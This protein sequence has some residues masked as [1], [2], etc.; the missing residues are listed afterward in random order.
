M[1]T[2]KTKQEISK[3]REGGKILAFVL[4]EL[5]KM[6]KPGTNLQDLENKAREL[7]SKKGAEPSFLGHKNYPAIICAS[8]NEEVVH[9]PPEKRAL[10]QGDVLSLDCGVKYKGLYT[11]SAITFPIGKVSPQAKKLIKVTKEALDKA[12]SVA[13]PK[14]TIGDISAAIQN[15][16]E[17]KGFSVVKSLVG[18]GVGHAIHE[19]PRIPNF[20]E[21]GT[22]E[23]IKPG[24]VFAF[25]PMVN[26]GAS[27]V[28]FGKDGWRVTTRDK[29]ISAHFE[30]TVVVTEHGCEVLTKQ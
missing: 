21:P 15:Y 27:Q 14:A 17:P 30:H 1:I 6:A 16:V 20:G 5:K 22:G 26:I 4:A 3:L 25:E 2:I 24:M 9:C 8:V 13:K 19:D 18:H 12:I 7:I 10:K 11:D 28:D 29:T 23:V